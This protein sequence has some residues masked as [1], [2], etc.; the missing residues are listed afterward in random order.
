MEDI[1]VCGTMKCPLFNSNAWIVAG[2]ME[3]VLGRV[4]KHEIKVGNKNMRRGGNLWEWLW[5]VQSSVAV[6]ALVLVLVCACVCSS[7][8]VPP[9]LVW[10]DVCG[11]LP[12][13][14]SP[15]M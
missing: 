1:P 8:V 12:R 9:G 3:R 10:A 2:L 5:I 7:L 14:E 11:K 6:P 15:L 4:Q 13:K